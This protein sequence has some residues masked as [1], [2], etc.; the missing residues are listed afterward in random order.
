MARNDQLVT[1]DGADIRERRQRTGMTIAEAAV[2]AHVSASTWSNAERSIEI[3]TRSLAKILNSLPAPPTP[4]DAPTPTAGGVALAT[5]E[6]LADVRALL[7]ELGRHLAELPQANP[8]AWSTALRKAALGGDPDALVPA[9]PAT[10]HRP[11]VGSFDP[12]DDADE[13]VEP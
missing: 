3:S 11:K 4:P 2:V 10:L 6:D 13:D 8:A 1:P 5:A 12:D 7:S 9:G